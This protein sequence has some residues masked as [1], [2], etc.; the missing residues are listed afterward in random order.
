MC[1]PD[2]NREEQR[3]STNAMNRTTPYLH[4]VRTNPR[5]ASILPE[6][7]TGSAPRVINTRGA[8]PTLLSYQSGNCSIAIFWTTKF[9]SEGNGPPIKPKAEPSQKA[10]VSQIGMPQCG[11]K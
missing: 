8:M 4:N 5:T 2:F 3:K 6:D 11:I 1:S 7:L 9:A 10:K